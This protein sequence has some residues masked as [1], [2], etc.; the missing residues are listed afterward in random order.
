MTNAKEECWNLGWFCLVKPVV[1][2]GSVLQ[3]L[4]RQFDDFVIIGHTETPQWSAEDSPHFF[5]GA[6][7]EQKVC[8]KS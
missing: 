5:V 3:F 4:G 2:P 6:L 8:F 1:F 7:N